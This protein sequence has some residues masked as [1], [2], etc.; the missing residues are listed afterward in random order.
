[1]KSFTDYADE[2]V[3]Q[4]REAGTQ[5][6]RQD[7]AMRRSFQGPSRLPSTS[8]LPLLEE[9]GDHAHAV[10]PLREFLIVAGR[11]KGVVRRL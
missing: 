3:G 8:P 9:H 11:R 5:L 7:Q 10:L 2:V 4:A 6:A 1:M